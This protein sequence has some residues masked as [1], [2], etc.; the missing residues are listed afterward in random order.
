MMRSRAHTL[1]LLVWTAMQLHAQTLVDKPV[2]LEGGTP[3]DRQVIGLHNATATGDAVNA[4]TLQ[5]AG[6][7]FAEAS[8][9]GAWQADLQPAIT[10]LQPGLCLLVRSPE[11]NSGPITLSLNGGAAVEIRKDGGM[12]L[13]AGDVAAG[14][15]MSLVHDGTVFQLVS[16]RRLERKPCPAGTVAVNGQYCIEL[17]ERDTLMFDLAAV[18]CGSDG[19]R[20]CSWGQWYAACTQ[21]ASL[22]LQAMT[23]EW[24]WTNSAANGDGS[25]RAVGANS[26]THAGIGLGWG[27]GA[28][29]RN[30][31][32]CFTR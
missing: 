26:C 13:G 29:A 5:H 19:M 12:P 27:E 23:G 2:I 22:G 9:S 17:Q 25:V 10:A 32:C 3:S 30:F 31:R 15:L 18:A 8:G 11:T 7:L 1:T 20:L 4:R 28:I 21:A 24:E 14:E 6:Y 16:A